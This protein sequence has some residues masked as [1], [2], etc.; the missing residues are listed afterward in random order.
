[1]VALKPHVPIDECIGSVDVARGYPDRRGISLRKH[2]IRWCCTF[3]E[4]H[5][6]IAANKVVVDITERC[7]RH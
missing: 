5:R 1:M 2:H 3:F 4:M 6:T 7:V